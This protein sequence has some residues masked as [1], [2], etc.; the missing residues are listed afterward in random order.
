MSNKFDNEKEDLI[1]DIEDFS[2]IA[3]TL[4]EVIEKVIKISEFHIFKLIKNGFKDAKKNLYILKCSAFGN[5]QSKA[6]IRQK[7]ST[8]R[9]GCPFKIAIKLLDDCSW[10]SRITNPVHGT[11]YNA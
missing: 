3:A 10:S 5:Y 6:A 4:N 1:F 7:T 11:D 2:I 9:A 8:V